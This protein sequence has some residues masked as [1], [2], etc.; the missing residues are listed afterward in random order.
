[1]D[2]FVRHLSTAWKNGE[3]RATH[4]K[5]PAALRWWRTREDP[6]EDVWS[7]VQHWLNEEPDA[8][9]KEL[10]QRLQQHLPGSFQHGQLRTLQR[11]VK[12][13]RTAVAKQLV[14]GVDTQLSANGGSHS[15][16]KSSMEM[17]ASPQTPGI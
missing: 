16:E 6:F 10:F 1:V 2:Q 3:I 12:E 9:G 5:R 11:R 8:T 14:L 13:W 15:E 7:T 17:G 4:R